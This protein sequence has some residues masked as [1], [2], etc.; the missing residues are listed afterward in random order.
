MPNPP[1]FDLAAAHKY[2]SADCFNRAW[3]LIDKPVRSAEE[4]RM[5]VLLNQ[6]SLYH[7]SQRPDNDAK[8]QSIGYWQASRIQVLLGNAVEARRYADI[9]LEYSRALEP[10]YLGY[11]YE[12]LARAASLAGNRAE[13]E[14]FLSEARDL[15]QKVASRE[16]RDALLKDLAGMK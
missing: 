1:E 12:A 5:M 4:E 16:D 6:A 14:Q 9:C 15:A 13:F 7:W 11:A 10:F 2:F 3:D 8:S